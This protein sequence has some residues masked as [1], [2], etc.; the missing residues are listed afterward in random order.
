LRQLLAAVVTPKL[1]LKDR[2]ARKVKPAKLAQQDRPV[3]KDS[4]DLPDLKVLRAKRVR[5]VSKVTMADLVFWRL[6]QV[7]Q[8]QDR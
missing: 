4:Q 6:G 3:F 8:P 7:S 2:L 5:P 1:G